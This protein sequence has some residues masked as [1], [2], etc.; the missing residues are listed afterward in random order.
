MEGVSP[1]SS[2]TPTTKEEDLKSNESLFRQPEE[3]GRPRTQNC[4]INSP[5]GSNRPSLP[6][7]PESSSPI[8]PG[9][10]VGSP[11]AP[12]SSWKIQQRDPE[13]Y[14]KDRVGKYAEFFVGN[15]IL[16]IPEI[17]KKVEPWIIALVVTDLKT[18]LVGLKKESFED[19]FRTSGVPCQYFCHKSFVTVCN[20]PAILRSSTGTAYGE[21]VPALPNKGRLSGHP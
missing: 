4:P 11:T 10:K 6:S 12:G 3:Q 18:R 9:Q 19:L 7:P 14:E 2:S 8:L 20:I 15:K 21:Y 1:S 16:P 17:V 13:D 5:I